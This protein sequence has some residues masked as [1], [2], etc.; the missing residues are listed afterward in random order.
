[1]LLTP[2]LTTR[3]MRRTVR[4]YES[5]GFTLADRFEDAGE[6]VF[7]RLTFGVADIALSPG[8]PEPRGVSLWFF[9]DRAQELYDLFK[10]R[11]A[12][13][14]ESFPETTDAALELRFAEDLY[15]PFYGGR[16]FSL[17]NRNGVDLILWQSEWLVPRPSDQG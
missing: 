1:V 7:A 13:A 6:L 16:Q 8:G 12:R 9:T 10:A 3:D 17:Q 11:Q 14:P 15:T 5:I 2:M 4:W